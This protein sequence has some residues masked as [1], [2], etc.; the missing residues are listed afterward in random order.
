MR[1]SRVNYY[2]ELA[3]LTSERSTCQSR[4]VG[5]VLVEADSHRVKSIGYNGAPSGIEHCG[6]IKRE[7]R[8]KK[9][10]VRAIHAEI[11]ALSQIKA[12]YKELIA[13]IT[14]APCMSCYQALVAFNVKRIYYIED[15][16]DPIRDELVKI[17]GVPLIKV[18]L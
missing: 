2:L 12:Y 7:V 16:D 8:G 10:C 9:T 1:I 5:C 17:Y 4:R 3:D 15:Y 18:Q 11:S 13:Y 6:C 14:C